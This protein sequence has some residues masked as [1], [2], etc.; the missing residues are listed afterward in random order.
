MQNPFLVA[1]CKAFQRHLKVWFD[2]SWG[3]KYV[4]ITYNS[5]KVCLHKFKYKMQIP[6]VREC[7]N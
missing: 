7:I 4:S 3:K 6:F 5:L 2:V 1:I